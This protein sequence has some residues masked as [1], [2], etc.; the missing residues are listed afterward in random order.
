MEKNML[1]LFG[2]PRECG[3]TKELFDLFIQEWNNIYPDTN[4]HMF[5]V[6]QENMAP[7]TACG[8]CRYKDGAAFL[9]TDC[10]IHCTAM[11]MLWL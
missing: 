3:F 5:H 11:R 2:S 9:I 6:Y 4:I 1:V 10:L 7:C 8:F